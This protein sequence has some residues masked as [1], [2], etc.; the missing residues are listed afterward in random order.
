[1]RKYEKIDTLYVRDTTGTKKLIEGKF[2]DSTVEFLAPC[3][4]IWTE[5]VDGCLRNDTK[6]LQTNG[7][8]ITI[9]AAV[10]ANKPIEIYGYKDGKVVPTKVLAFHNNG[11]GNEWY[12][13]KFNRRGLGTKGNSYGIIEATPNHKF[14]INGDYRRADELKIG[15]KVTYMRE[16]QLLTFIQEQIL[17]GLILGDGSITDEGKS[18][19]FSH[20]IEHESYIDW[21]L[22][23]LGNLAGNKQAVRTSGYGT[24]IIP[25]RTIS[26][27]SIEN[28]SKKFF[29]NKKKYIPNDLILSPIALAILYCDDGNLS[30]ESGQ[31]DRCMIHLN[32]YDEESV[33]NFISIIQRQYGISP[34]KLNSKGWNVRF[35]SKEALVLQTLIAPYVCNCMQYKLSTDFQ[36]RF[37]GNLCSGINET[38]SKLFEMEILDIEVKHENHFR[39][40]LTTETHNYFANGVLVHNCNIRVY[41][42]GHTVTFGGRTDNA[43]IPAELVT[44]LNAKF[45]GEA[46]A[47]MFEQMFGEKEVI[48]FGEGYGRKIQKGGGNYISDGVDFI[49]FDVLIGENYLERA[50]VEDIARAMGIKVVPIVGTGSLYEAVEYV[51]KHPASVVAEGRCEME[52]IVARPKIEMRDRRG[53]RLICKI[54]WEDMREII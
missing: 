33:D 35:N 20:K 34:V 11:N 1:M 5:K 16:E 21:I 43:Q 10:E 17:I 26:Y 31:L 40:D 18:I 15:D 44:K 45:G 24:Q 4:W 42:D 47:Q 48:L 30:H 50:N 8:Y 38:S 22:T 36:N 25:A 13:I 6:L 9:K 37:I 46:N 28:L 12:K 54:K 32:D 27:F 3:E 23:G 39:Y 51:K 19:E 53:N 52:G 7:E 41:W 14:F 49:L 29:K 2:R